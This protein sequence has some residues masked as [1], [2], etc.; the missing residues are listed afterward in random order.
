M[1]ICASSFLYPFYIVLKFSVIEFLVHIDDDRILPH[2]K[3]SS[4]LSNQLLVSWMSETLFP[5]NQALLGGIFA[6]DFV[7][8][9]KSVGAFVV[10]FQVQNDILIKAA[11]SCWE[12]FLSG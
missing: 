2:Q 11:E 1:L 9:G 5:H 7:I 4:H 8:I 10:K 12:C 6:L 3:F